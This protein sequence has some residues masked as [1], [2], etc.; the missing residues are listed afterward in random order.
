MLRLYPRSILA[1]MNSVSAILRQRSSWPQDVTRD[2]REQSFA[3]LVLHRK[4][5]IQVRSG[6]LSIGPL[7]LP[8][9]GL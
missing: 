5:H 1:M 9:P 2:P 6:R 8:C 7:E 3:K 4:V